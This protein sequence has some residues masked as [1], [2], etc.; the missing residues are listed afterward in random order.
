LTEL[1]SDS[2]THFSND[3]TADPQLFAD[4]KEIIQADGKVDQ[5]EMNALEALKRMIDHRSK[6]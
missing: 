5:S 4:L 2:I 3:A 6:A 1:L